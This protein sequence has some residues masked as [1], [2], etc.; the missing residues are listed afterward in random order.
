V[1][2]RLALAALLTRALTGCGAASLRPS[3]ARPALGSA[4]ELAVAALARWED[5]ESPAG[6]VA[7][8][9]SDAVCPD[10]TVRER[11]R[12]HMEQPAA[13]VRVRAVRSG[14]LFIFS[15]PDLSDHVHRARV[16][17]RAD[18][19]LAVRAESEN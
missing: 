14:W 6:I 11:L 5:V 13:N 3:P 15:F 16:W 19:T 12:C 9:T 18:G 2:R 1:L 8:L 17:R 7:A 10:G 4:Y